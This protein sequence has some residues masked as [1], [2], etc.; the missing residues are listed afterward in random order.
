MNHPVT[1]DEV[2]SFVQAHTLIELRG[3]LDTL[4]DLLVDDPA[5]F[6]E[7]VCRSEYYIQK[8]IWWEHAL[9]E[10]G[11]TLGLGGPRDPHDP[12]HFYSETYL[13]D[14]FSPDTTL[15]EYLRY[16]T[17]IREAHPHLS[18]HPG[19][20]LSPREEKTQN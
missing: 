12:S 9:I 14:K 10:T 6:A 4:S 19:F 13:V 17:D 11:S 3:R 8:V 1:L 7:L 20:D 16:M 5:A 15:E 18:L 2:C